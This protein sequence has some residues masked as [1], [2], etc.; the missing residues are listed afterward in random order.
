MDGGIPSVGEFVGLPD[1][2]PLLP[3]PMPALVKWR[4]HKSCRLRQRLKRRL[5]VFRAAVS[6]VN[7]IN[8]L[9][10][11]RVS[12]KLTAPEAEERGR[13]KV[14][15]ARQLALSHVLSRVALEV[16]ARRSFD[17][18]GVQP[19]ASLLKASLDESGYVRPAGVRQVAMV[20]ERMVEPK[21]DGHIDVLDALPAE[22]A[23]YYACEENV[24]ETAG[25]SSVLFEEIESHYGFIGGE[26]DEFLRYLRRPDVGYLWE[27]DLMSNV[28]AVAGVS[29]VLKK[30]G[31]DQRKLIMQC[32]ANYMFGDPSSRAHLGM[33]GGASLARVFVAGDS[34]QVSACDEDSAFTYVKVPGWMAKWQAAPPIP[35]V[36]AWDL[37]PEDLK[38]SIDNKFTTMVSPKYLRLAMGGSHSVYILMR[39]NLQHIGRTLF[40]YASRLRLTDDDRHA[41]DAKLIEEDCVEDGD[42]QVLADDEWVHQHN[43]LKQQKRSE[44]GWTVDE[45]RDE[46][47]RS[48]H[49]AVRTCVVVHMFAGER[50]T[51][52]VQ[53]YLEIL[54]EQQGPRT[55]D[56]LC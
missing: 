51:N 30:N 47:R 37:L 43:L 22:D 55:F 16:R 53:E 27:W 28:K 2:W 23:A 31:H 10:T 46:V 29:V 6:V 19:L 38:A 33:G 17:L 9:H 54:M 8:A 52:D 32:A 45:W 15:A 34:M 35:A 40:N 18:T 50:R 24:V 12:T 42:E 4:K 36:Q 20:A 44:H 1:V 5:Q 3:L 49:H 13:M 14:T 56:D 21:D 39:I 11:G 41:L 26:L 7:L 48:K 25:K